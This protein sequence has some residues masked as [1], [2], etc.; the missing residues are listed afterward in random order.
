MFRSRAESRQGNG[1][2]F[3]LVS[4]LSLSIPHCLLGRPL[5]RRCRVL[6]ATGTLPSSSGVS[7]APAP[8]PA[9]SALPSTASAARLHSGDPSTGW[10]RSPSASDEAAK[11][12][13]L[14]RFCPLPDDVAAAAAVPC[15][16]PPPAGAVPLLLVGAG[17]D[18]GV[19]AGS[20]SAWKSEV[21]EN[22]RALKE[23]GP[24]IDEN[25]EGQ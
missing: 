19:L 11:D 4:L 16:W 21:D 10:G 18:L 6:L 2:G 13:C 14:V 23:P 15:P 9:P 3:S 7:S 8:S 5:D 22:G 12:L 25:D 20:S 17:G 1:S 24:K